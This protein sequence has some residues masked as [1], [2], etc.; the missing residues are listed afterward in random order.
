[1]NR[2]RQAAAVP[3]PKPSKRTNNLPRMNMNQHGWRNGIMVAA[4]GLFRQS[5]LIC[6][7]L[8]QI[9][10]F[11]SEL[12]RRMGSCEHHFR[13]RER[14]VSGDNHDLEWSFRF[15]P[16]PVRKAAAGR[17]SLGSSGCNP[18]SCAR[19]GMAKAGT[20]SAKSQ[21]TEQPGVRALLGAGQA[22]GP[23]L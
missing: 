16:E 12:D 11:G 19:P 13:K 6:V 1:M 14:P 22:E 8:W 20:D 5:V 9:A 15:R 18:G 10:G 17:G 3:R 23:Q 21:S 4:E 2:L 7:H